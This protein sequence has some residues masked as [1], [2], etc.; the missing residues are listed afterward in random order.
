MQTSEP[1]VNVIDG[2]QQIV[3]RTSLAEE[4]WKIKVKARMEMLKVP[5]WVTLNSISAC[6]SNL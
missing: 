1:S 3:L 4:I 5:V 2:Q 6:F